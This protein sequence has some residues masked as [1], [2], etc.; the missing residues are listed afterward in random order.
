MNIEI[1]NA[2]INFTDQQTVSV[3]STF[4]FNG[5]TEYFSGTILIPMSELK[6]MQYDE[7]KR[8]TKSELIKRLT[9]ETE[10]E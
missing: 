8:A 7:L 4:S 9:A 3:A 10:E 1:T 2:T 6:S 5:G